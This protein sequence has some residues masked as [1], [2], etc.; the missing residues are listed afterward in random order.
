LG[1]FDPGQGIPRRD[2][3][4]SPKASECK[5]IIITRHNQIS[6]ATDGR[7]QNL[8]VICISTY[9]DCKF[10]MRHKSNES[11]IAIEQILNHHA[12]P[13]NRLL[14][15]RALQHALQLSQQWHA[16]DEPNLAS[17]CSINDLAWYALPDQPRKSRIGIKN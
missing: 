9:G 12:S 13:Q 11:G 14:E 7:S 8:I 6:I 10:I 16:A 2:D 4:N 5:Q 1:R 17:Q 15:L 3:F